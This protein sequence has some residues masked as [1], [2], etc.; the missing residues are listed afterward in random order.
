[1]NSENLLFYKIK[2]RFINLTRMLKN[3]SE[4]LVNLHELTT[5]LRNTISINEKV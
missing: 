5:K 2:L 1:M 3:M 4:T